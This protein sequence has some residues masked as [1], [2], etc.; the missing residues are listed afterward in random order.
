M[1][2]AAH[3]RTRVLLR[4]RRGRARH[5]DHAAGRAGGDRPGGTHRPAGGRAPGGLPGVLDPLRQLLHDALAREPGTRRGNLRAVARPWIDRPSHG[6]PV[7]RPGAGDVPARPLHQGHLPALR[8]EG[9]ER[10]QLR[11]VRLDLCAGRPDRS[12]FHRHRRPAG[13]EGVRAL[14]PAPLRLPG[15]SGG[16]GRRWPPAERGRQQ[17]P[18]VVRRRP[19]RLG[20]LP[21]RALLRLRDS[22]RDRGQV[23]LRVGG[24]ADR[25][26]GQLPP[27][28]RPPNDVE[29]RR[30]LGAGQRHRAVPLHRQGHP[31]L[32]LPVLARRARTAA[33]T[34]RRRRCSFT[35]S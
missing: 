11:R 18:R 25:L 29:L 35:A 28:L 5:A 31:L 27:V 23:L 3:A 2:L 16:L 26:H 22:R 33:V 7:L 4:L 14:L 6:A 24:C 17:A 10:R 21:R 8:R 34:A 32:P 20:H 30:V 12:P 15:A 13:G 1:P 9:P 19:P